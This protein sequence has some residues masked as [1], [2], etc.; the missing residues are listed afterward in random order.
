MENNTANRMK[1]AEE[2]LDENFKHKGV[3][4]LI[5]KQGLVYKATIKAMETY[6]T[7]QTAELTTQLA[8]ANSD[9]E[10][11]GELLKRS[12]ETVETDISIMIEHSQDGDVLDQAN[13]Y[14]NQIKQT[15]QD[16]GITL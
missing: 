16:C 2:V 4:N 5:S 9:K 7:Q 11:L 3:S 6:A 12:L 1:E 10:R 15:L 14:A 8:K 13:F